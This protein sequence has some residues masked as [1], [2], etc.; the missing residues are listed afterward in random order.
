MKNQAIPAYS[1]LAEPVGRDATG[2]ALETMGRRH[3][4]ELSEDLWLPGGTSGLELTH[5][6]RVVLPA[7]R[8]GHI[9]FALWLVEAFRPNTIVELGVRSG[10]SYCAFLQAVQMLGLPTRCYGIGHWKGDDHA[11][12]HG[13]QVYDELRSYHDPRYGHFSSLL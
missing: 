3:A 9:P 2:S 7:T 13:E 11:M 6:S 4:A 1:M 5:P 8:L 12:P 10:N